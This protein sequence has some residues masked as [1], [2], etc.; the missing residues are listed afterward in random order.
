[1]LDWFGRLADSVYALGYPGVVVAL[2]IE[3]LGLPFPGDAVMAFYG[4]AAAEHSLS[5]WGV[6]LASVAGYMIGTTTSYT[7]SYAFGGR[8]MEAVAQWPW[9]SQRSMRRTTNLLARYGPLLLIPGRFLPG[10]RSGS[11]Y[12][13]GLAKMEFQPF[14][15]YTGVSA[16]IWCATWVGVGY[17]FGENLTAILQFASSSLAY[18]TG[19]LLL[20]ALAFLWWRYQR[21]R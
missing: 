10:V 16:V 18:L 19:A 20:C 2:V 5:F 4:V 21:A 15:I 7:V 9:F 3:G 17:W 6:V 12:V 14:F 11:S 13:A 1:M 8:M